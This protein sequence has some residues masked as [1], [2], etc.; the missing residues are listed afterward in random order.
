MQLDRFCLD[1][2]LIKPLVLFAVHR[3]VDVIGLSS[4]VAGSKEHLVLVEGVEGHDRRRRIKEG[5]ILR[6]AQLL[7]AFGKRTVGQRPAGNDGRALRNLV[8]TLVEYSDAGVGFDFFGNIIRK[9]L[10]VHRQR[11]SGRN[12]SLLCRLHG[13]RAEHPHLFLEHSGC[14]ANAGSL[15]GIGADQ[16]SKALIVMSRGVV[17]RLHLI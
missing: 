15:E 5:K 14:R 13:Q 11:T 8:H 2:R 4:A 1:Q 6:S 7:D 10:A 9:A 17:V 16:L 12:S 3:T